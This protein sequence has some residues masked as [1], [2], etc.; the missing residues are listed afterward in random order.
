MYV[1]KMITRRTPWFVLD[2]NQSSIDA[3]FYALSTRPVLFNSV[4]AFPVLASLV[5]VGWMTDSATSPNH[6]S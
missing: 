4:H 6:K 3:F 2:I 1:D 5:T